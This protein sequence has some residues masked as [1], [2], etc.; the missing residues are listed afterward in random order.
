MQSMVE[1]QA[2][3]Q[4]ALWKALIA[5]LYGGIF[6]EVSVR[7]FVMTAVVW[8]WSFVVSRIRREPVQAYPGTLWVGVLFA[9]LVFGIGHLAA[10]AQMGYTDPVL[11]V[12]TLALNAVPGVFF[13]LLYMRFGISAAV[14]AHFTADIFLHVVVPA[15]GG[16]LA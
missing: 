10:L 14:V 16:T 15:L 9:A 6:E 12:R 7:L 1:G 8:F 2:L 11:V 3:R 5:S 4:P 13:G